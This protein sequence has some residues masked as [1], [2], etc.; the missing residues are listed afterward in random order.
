MLQAGR[1]SYVFFHKLGMLSSS[2]LDR[3]IALLAATNH[4]RKDAHRNL[5]RELS[6]DEE[7]KI[8]SDLSEYGE[9]RNFIYDYYFR[10]SH[11]LSL[12]WGQGGPKVAM[13]M[14]EE[15]IG[16]WRQKILENPIFLK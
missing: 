9:D 8:Y 13:W 5:R 12:Q 2:K 10:E 4:L 7:V 1:D 6:G 11:N 3:L 15:G 16:E 14:P